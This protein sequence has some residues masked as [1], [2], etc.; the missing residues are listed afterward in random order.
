LFLKSL[1]IIS[2]SERNGGSLQNFKAATGGD[3]LRYEVKHQQSTNNFIF[4]GLFVVIS[5]EHLQNSDNSSGIERRRITVYFKRRVS[6]EQK[7]DWQD[8]GGESAVLYAELPGLVNWLL[9][10]S[11]GDITRII[12]NQTDRTKQANFDAMIESNS[13]AGWLVE[14]CMPD[15]DAETQIGDGRKVT[16]PGSE[17]E[18]KN[19]KIQLYPSYLQWASRNGKS[20]V[21]S[22]RFKN[23]LLDTVQTLS[24]KATH[25]RV[26]AGRFIVGIRLRK[27]WENSESFWRNGGKA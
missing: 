10:L 20:P 11:Q 17:A 9:E 21:S 5:N 22:T 24:F 18:Y 3:P 13:V 6:D 7:R 27:D 2:D 14:C 16:E 1:A 23:L 8:R 19:F 12:Q 4:K 26:P 25:R 15:K